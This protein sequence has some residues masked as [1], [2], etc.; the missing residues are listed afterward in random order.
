M[1]KEKWTPDQLSAINLRP[2]KMLVSAAAGSGKTAVLSERI[3]KRLEDP[4]A[5]I[6][7]F[8][9]VTYTR[10]AASELR[11][12]IGSKLRDKAVKVDGSLA[13]H[14]AR[15]CNRLGSAHISTIHS[16][17]AALV[18]RNFNKFDPPLPPVLNVCEEA[19][20]IEIK[21]RLMDELIESA[22]SGEFA[23]ITNFEAF[24]NN[25]VT[26]NDRALADEML[27]HYQTVQGL[28]C[29]FETW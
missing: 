12:R 25:F 7:R 20:A 19:Q 2:K 8:L 13:K 26:A 22:Y 29:G 24:A 14:F 16:Y 27:R 15:Q 23:P 1:A 6:T 3:I 9:I 4:N 18:K 28:P 17:C 5:D 21:T 11:S 10:L